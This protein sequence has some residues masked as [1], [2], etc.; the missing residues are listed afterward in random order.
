LVLQV[1]H[2]V[3]QVLQE[4]HV[5]LEKLL[6]GRIHLCLLLCT[7]GTAGSPCTSHWGLINT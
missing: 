3:G 2:S 7:A 1:G 5:I 6:H 4:L